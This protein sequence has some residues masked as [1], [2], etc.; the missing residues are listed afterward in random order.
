MEATP[1]GEEDGTIKFEGNEFLGYHSGGWHSLDQTAGTGTVSAGL[2]YKIPVYTASPSG[3]VVDDTSALYWKSNRLGVNED[4][5]QTDIHL[6][7]T[8]GGTIRLERNEP[9]AIVNNDKLGTIEFYGF[10]QAFNDFE[11]VGAKIVGEATG[12]WSYDADNQ[13]DR[14]T[15]LQFWTTSGI[16]TEDTQKRM[17]IEDTGVIYHEKAT[18][19]NI[20]DAGTVGGETINLDLDDS[21][22]H[23]ITLDG[24]LTLTFS[25]SKTGQ[26]FLVRVLQ[27]SGGGHTITWPAGI[28]W[29]NGVVGQPTTTDAKA[30][31]F[32]FI[33]TIGEPATPAYD[34]FV[35]GRNI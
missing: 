17:V 34:G 19:T 25:N 14:Q 11:G 26:R 18:Y 28:T 33:T 10:D 12:T 27:S 1:I 23:K 8:T 32:G 30:T 2:Q 7:S 6:K 3:T 15:E 9:G 31:V 29:V 5:P 35:V 22:L 21:D 4:D 16:N 20:E 24:N 13:H